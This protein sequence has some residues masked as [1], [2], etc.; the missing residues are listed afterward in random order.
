MG[1]ICGFDLTGTIKTSHSDVQKI[2][3]HKYLTWWSRVGGDGGQ[4]LGYPHQRLWTFVISE[5]IA[6]GEPYG[7]S[8]CKMN[9]FFFLGPHPRHMEVPRQEFE[10]ELQRLAY[11]TATATWDPSHICT[12]HHSSRQCQIPDPMIEARDQTHI[13][14]VMRWIHLCYA[15]TGAP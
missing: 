12:L 10:L 6:D 15:T 11:I 8:I 7:C 14:T 5:W 3:F 13:F 1:G 4:L 9:F 2:L